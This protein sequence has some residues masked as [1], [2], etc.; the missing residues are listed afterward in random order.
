MIESG[1]RVL[2]LAEGREYYVRA[3]AGTLQT[4]LGTL[5][6]SRLVGIEPGNTIASHRGILFTLRIP[7]AT[8]FFAHAPRSGAPMLPRD[9]G[10]VIAATGMNRNDSVLDAGTGS[11]ISAIYF[12]G[13]ARSVDTYE[14]RSEFAKIAEANIR[15]AKLE[16]VQV[17]AEDVL[18]ARGEYDVIHLDLSIRC[19]HVEHAHRLLRP[20]GYLACYTPFIEQMSIVMDASAGLFPEVHAH[21]CLDR[22]MTRTARGTRP[23][24][25]VGHSGYITIARK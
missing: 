22:E 17:F 3:G 16:N 9:I 14:Q 10:Y 7:R 2:L 11:G 24:T 1:D 19:E 20:G 21:E 8:D 25:R 15:D 18:A 5:D 6:L 12:G 13:I 23:S 4:D